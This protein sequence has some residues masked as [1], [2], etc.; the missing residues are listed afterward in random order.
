MAHDAP[1]HVGFLGPAGTFTEEALFTQRD[2]ATAKLTPYATMTDVLDAVQRGQEDLGFVPIENAIDGTVRDTIDALVFDTDL[3]I[4]REVVL[5][6][7]LHL[8]APR[9]TDIDRL[10]RVA[11]IPVA[12]A[13]CRKF[14]ASRLPEAEIVAT[15]STAEAARLVGE[16]SRDGLGGDRV[17]VAAIAPRLCADLYGLEIL[18]ADVEDHPDNQTRFVAVARSGIPAPTGHDRTSIACFQSSDHPGSLHGILG[19]FS[20]RNIN[21]TKLESRPTKRVLGEYCFIID[22]EGHVADAVVADCL[23]ELHV[24]LPEVKL[25]G[26]YPAAGAT[27][28]ARRREFTS[29]RL[30]ADR[31]LDSLLSQVSR[32]SP[33]GVPSEPERS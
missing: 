30:E 21:L 16:G 5:D 25:L 12:I 31:W 24:L 29:A 18:A 3:L 14:L 32:P 33:P 4:Q 8:M 6:I 1:R 27:G 13:Q 11:S 2:Y 7:H 20:A 23:R 22:L 17:A 28:P 26:S 15:T 10:G 9:G 19:Q